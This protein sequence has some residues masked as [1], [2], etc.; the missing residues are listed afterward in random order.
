MRT[1]EILFL[2]S[3]LDDWFF[4]L[5]LLS[6]DDHFIRLVLLVLRVIKGVEVG[7][8]LVSDILNRS[9]FLCLLHVLEDLE[10]IH[11][12]CVFFYLDRLLSSLLLNRSFLLLIIEG[13]EAVIAL[14]GW[15]INLVVLS[16]SLLRLAKLRLR[17]VDEI[18]KNGLAIHLSHRSDLGLSS[19]LLLLDLLITTIVDDD[20]PILFSFDL[21]FLSILSS[22]IEFGLLLWFS[23][24][25]WLSLLL[26]II[27]RLHVIERSQASV[28][29]TLISLLLLLSQGMALQAISLQCCMS[30]P[31]PKNDPQDFSEGLREHL[32]IN[33]LGK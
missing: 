28:S 8:I 12:G 29:V 14:G 23:L 33:C 16:I 10:E 1:L 18:I 13:V 15:H 9:G 2:S 31:S 21:L 27:I 22:K 4:N 7:V 17:L 24:L 32:N 11:R 5:S 3:D 20:N 19:F 25:H 6:W 26:L 30:T